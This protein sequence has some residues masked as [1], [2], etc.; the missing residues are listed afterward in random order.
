MADVQAFAGC[1]I[2]EGALVRFSLRVGET[3]ATAAAL[4]EGI[5]AHPS[6][7]FWA[8]DL[9]YRDVDPLGLQGHQQ[10]TDAN[11]AALATW[12]RGRLATFDQALAAA[13]PT[14][15]VSLP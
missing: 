13:R 5:R 15:R 8:D 2:V 11:L 7:E 14:A 6:C 4:I 9:P 10:V 1:P 3:S 12:H